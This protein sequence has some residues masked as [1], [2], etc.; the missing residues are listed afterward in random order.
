MT[1][2]LVFFASGVLVVLA[3]IALA[4]HADTIA[5]LTG[6]GRIWIGS[7]LL[8]G[9]SSLPEAATDVA[10]VRFGAPDLAAGDLFGSCMAN[11]F[12]LGVIDLLSRDLPVLR[13][14]AQDHALSAALAML[15]MSMAALFVL[16]RPSASV[17]GVG[18]APAFLFLVYVGGA[19]ALYRHSVRAP[20]ETG[21]TTRPKTKAGKASLRHA[22]MRFGAA[23]AVILVTSPCFAWAAQR[24]AEQSG[25]GDA[26]VG[27]LLV[28][29]STSLPEL[30]TSLAAVR[31]GA[32]DLAVGN[33]FGSNAFNMA[34]FIVL[35]LAQP[36]TTIFANLDPGHALSALLPLMMT[37]IA[38]AA[39]FYRAERRYAMIEPDSALLVLAY[40][41]SI[42]LL[43]TQ[44]GV[45]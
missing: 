25:L 12:I 18:L 23:A 26:F 42:G 31:A 29:F 30:V 21:V 8:A 1:A 2:V 40:V 32:L 14:A 39:V 34:L 17:L 3:G 22:M 36:G 41:M 45:P 6:L 15:L 11:M 24:I 7:M 20:A 35:D 28:G 33:L 13:R 16:L 5:E 9:A 27:T 44:S 10:A 19:R 4:R 38:V 37:S 43:Y